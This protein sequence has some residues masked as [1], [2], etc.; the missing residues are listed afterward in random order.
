MRINRARA[1]IGYVSELKS[2]VLLLMIFLGGCAGLQQPK[3]QTSES[4]ATKQNDQAENQRE[5]QIIELSNK[6]ARLELKLLEKQAEINQ[7]MMSQQNAI[8]EVV[9]AKAKLRSH[10]SKAGAVAN[11]IETKMALKAVKVEHLNEQ[12]KSVLSQVNDLIM[13]SD[14]ALDDGN[15]D[16]ATFLSGKAH[17]LILTI[18]TQDNNYGQSG[19]HIETVT[20][21]TPLTME[22]TKRSNVRD[23]PDIKSKVLFQLKSGFQVK[24]LWYSDK[25]IYIEDDTNRKGWIYYQLLESAQ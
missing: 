25:W 16:G 20:F 15:I 19:E 10:S 3:S 21:L 13:M 24:A 18:R 2:V 4:V 22:T 14:K 17:Q 7:L 8:R 6:N 1:V 11:V 5:L 23:K 12:Q 9:R